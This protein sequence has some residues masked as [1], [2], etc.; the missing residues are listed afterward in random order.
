MTIL[1]F[2][3]L[4]QIKEYTVLNSWFKLLEMGAFMGIVSIVINFI[5]IFDQ[6]MKKNTA[7]LLLAKLSKRHYK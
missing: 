1:L 2:I 3:F 7:S 6:K 5:F 4:W